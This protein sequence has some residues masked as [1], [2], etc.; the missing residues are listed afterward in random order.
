MVKLLVLAR[1]HV[2]RCRLWAIIKTKVEKGEK[3]SEERM[4]DVRLHGC[5]RSTHIYG[6]AYVRTR[7]CPTRS[8]Y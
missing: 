3:R 1:F 7:M 4:S 6:Y 5:P 8:L 2:E